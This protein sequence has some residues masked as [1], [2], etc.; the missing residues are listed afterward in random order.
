MGTVTNPKSAAW[1]I[2]GGL[3]WRLGRKSA[4]PSRAEIDMFLSGVGPGSRCAIVGASTKELVETAIARQMRVT[5]LDFSSATLSDLRRELGEACCKYV[6]L[7]VLQPIPERM[8]N[9]LHIVLA[10]RLV[11]RFTRQDVPVFLRNVLSLLRDAGELRMTVKLG[12]YPMDLALIEEGHARGTIGR[13][14]DEAT[15]T[16]DYSQASEEL[17]KRLVPHGSIPR[18]LLLRWYHGRGKESRFTSNDIREMLA[19]VT[20]G[21]RQFAHINEV[22]CSDAP[23]TM[24]YYASIEDLSFAGG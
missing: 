15:R 13:F 19:E 23:N 20:E 12:F 11:N 5:V 7:D 21:G 17:E 14:Y 16:I 2:V 6:H 1:D 24:M 3:F 18:A 22:S 10:D 9:T 4:R 8:R